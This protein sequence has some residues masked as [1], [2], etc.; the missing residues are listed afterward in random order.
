M[1]PKR[2]AAYVRVSSLD[3]NTEAQETTLREYVQRRC[4]T[5]HKIYRDE[6]VSGTK[7]ADQRWRFHNR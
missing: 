3:Q 6:G 1:K 5:L 7:P 4:W 2:A